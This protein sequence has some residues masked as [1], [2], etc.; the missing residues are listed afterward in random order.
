M[1]KVFLQAKT[2]FD[3]RDNLKIIK[4]MAMVM[5]YSLMVIDLSVNFKMI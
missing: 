1:G 3:T 2:V 4:C 5:K